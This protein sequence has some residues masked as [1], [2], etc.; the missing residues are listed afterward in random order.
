MNQL[1]KI[2]SKIELPQV[3]I[4]DWTEYRMIKI[5]NYDNVTDWN[6]KQTLY[7]KKDR[8]NTF[9]FMC[10]LMKNESIKHIKLNLKK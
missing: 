1:I 9:D 5:S 2:N 4:V 8:F 10:S 3:F 6:R 7:R